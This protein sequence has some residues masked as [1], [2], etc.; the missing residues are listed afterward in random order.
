MDNGSGGTY[1]SV[2]IFPTDCLPSSVPVAVVSSG[3]RESFS[4]ET[5]NIKLRCMLRYEKYILCFLWINIS[6]IKC[7]YKPIFEVVSIT[8]SILSSVNWLVWR[9]RLNFY[10]LDMILM[11]LSI[12]NEGHITVAL[13]RCNRSQ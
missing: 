9:E 13:C 5:Y 6:Q 12:I 1:G 11:R 3:I 4:K 2:I 7:G 8:F 10:I